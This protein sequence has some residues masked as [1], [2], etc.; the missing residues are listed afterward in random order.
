MVRK[1]KLRID[2]NTFE[3]EVDGPD[4]DTLHITIG[5]TTFPVKLIEGNRITGKYKISVGE[6]EHLI[7]ITPTSGAT[8]Y[9]VSLNKQTYAAALH[10]V[11]ATPSVQRQ[12]I[13]PTSSPSVPVDI[14]ATTPGIV[15]AVEPGTVTAPL[16]GRV[17][18]VHV[19]LNKQILAG[20]VLLVLEAMKMANEIRAPH[21]GIVSVVHVENG[22]A[23]EKGQALVTIR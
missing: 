21:D 7:Q 12:S 2:D 3:V 6:T 18:E 20:D 10:P 16:P 15:E 5:E 8:P 23:V 22:T 1:Y 4:K 9:S 13:A 14:T 19:T 17:L 11:S